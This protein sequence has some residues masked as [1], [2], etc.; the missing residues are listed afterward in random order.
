MCSSSL[1]LLWCVCVCVDMLV[2]TKERYTF[3]EFLVN[4]TNRAQIP[5][6]LTI[7]L[8]CSFLSTVLFIQFYI[9]TFVNKQLQTIQFY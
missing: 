8:V 2:A 3:S 6:Y 4:E 9:K 7:V 5:M 1:Y